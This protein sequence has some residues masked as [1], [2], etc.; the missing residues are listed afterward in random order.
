MVERCDYYSNDEYEYAQQLERDEFYEALARDEYERELAEIAYQ[1]EQI[2]QKIS[3]L[4]GDYKCFD[5]RI[6]HDE[7][8]ILCNM[9]AELQRYRNPAK[10]AAEADIEAEL[11]ELP[12][13]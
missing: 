10:E 4:A 6:S 5:H 2:I 3:N 1:E 12:F 8:L 11:D 13:C 9:L 7:A